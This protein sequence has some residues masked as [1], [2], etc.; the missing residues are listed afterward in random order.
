MFSHDTGLLRWALQSARQDGHPGGTPWATDHRLGSAA[1]LPP[2]ARATGSESFCSS[3][4]HQGVTGAVA[5]S[6]GTK[7]TEPF[8]L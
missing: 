6:L 5:E 2:V 1:I 7:P 3:S 8:S 4:P